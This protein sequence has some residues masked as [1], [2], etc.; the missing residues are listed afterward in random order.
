MFVGSLTFLLSL[1]VASRL[2]ESQKLRLSQQ[3]SLTFLLN[4]FEF[5]SNKNSKN[6]AMGCKKKTLFGFWFSNSNMQKQNG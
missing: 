3:L 4:S 6:A 2:L 5:S 1:V